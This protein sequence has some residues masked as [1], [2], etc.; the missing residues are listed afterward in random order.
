MAR[1]LAVIPACGESRR[2]QRPKLLL[3]WKTSTVIA[4]VVRSWL[5][6]PIDR[7]LIVC[8]ASDAPLLEHLEELRASHGQRLEIIRLDPPPR[9]MKASI[10]AAIQHLTREVASCD[11]QD[12]PADYLAIA[13]GDLPRLP[14]AVISRLLEQIPTDAV[15]QPSIAGRLRH[16]VLLP[17]SVARQILKLDASETLATLVQRASCKA[18]PCDDLASPRD[19]ADLDTPEAYQQLLDD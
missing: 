15:V 18:V 16:P 4:A 6:T 7:L 2:M 19:F 9:E 1:A 12:L 5:S 10:A 3:P 8:R 13:P 14:A 11:P 17:W